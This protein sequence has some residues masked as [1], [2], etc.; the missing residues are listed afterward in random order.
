MITGLVLP[1]NIPLNIVHK[2]AWATVGKLIASYRSGL[3][4]T[5]EAFS[6]NGLVTLRP[7]LQP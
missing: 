1:D 5:S 3:K 7:R 6:L 4:D 2:Y